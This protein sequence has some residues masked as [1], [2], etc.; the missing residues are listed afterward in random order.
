M[1]RSPSPT[2]WRKSSYSG[3]TGDCVE[4]GVLPSGH[5]G[6]RDSKN[7][8]GP[9]LEVSKSGWRAFLSGIRTDASV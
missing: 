2:R 3:D 9:V 8:T 4:V 1:H 5:I 7:P 6:I